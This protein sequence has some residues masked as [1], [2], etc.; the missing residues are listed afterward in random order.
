M[1]RKKEAFTVVTPIPGFIPRQLAIDILHSHSEVIGVNPLVLGHKPITAPRNAA[2]DEFYSTWYEIEERIQYIP[3]AGKFGSG[4]ISFNGC[5]HN[6]PWGLQTHIYAPM[7]IDL[8]N[9]Y[10]ISGNQ[11]GIEPPEH[12]EI[13]LESLGA[14]SDGLYLREDIE[15]K[16]N[17]T[18]VSFVKAQLKAASKEMVHRIIKKAELLD[19]G[20]LKAM[21]ED[22]KLR[23]VNPN[24]RSAA[25]QDRA[26]KMAEAQQAQQGH[27]YLTPMSPQLANAAH[28]PPSY[29]PTYPMYAQ[30]LQVPTSPSPQMYH[31]QNP[32]YLQQGGYAPPPV[33]P[34]EQIVAM[35]LPG[36]YMYYHQQQPSPGRTSSGQ[37]S[38]GFP[39]S[40]RSSVNADPRLSQQ[41]SPGMVDPHRMSGNSMVSNGATGGYPGFVNELA[42]HQEHK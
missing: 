11:P 16:C 33:P 8:R 41:L 21:M 29:S 37:P 34:K 32:Y 18:M 31:H 39:N 2:A 42:A 35:E 38:P 40:N 23:T 26:S 9:T 12:R 6:M 25:S 30:P 27:P 19:A 22:G 4:K 28:L 5:F 36:D 3:G 13:G 24:D 20:V 14:P 10:R 15:F 1:L 17:I 7:N